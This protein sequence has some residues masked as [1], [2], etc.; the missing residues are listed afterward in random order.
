MIL[1]TDRLIMRP[2][3]DA[4]REPFAAMNADPA[5][6]EYFPAPLTREE[7]DAFVD[8]IVANM[9]RDGYGLWALEV[10]NRFIGYTGLA[11]WTSPV[12]GDEFVE[13]GWRLA[14]H[15]W[16]HGYATEAA[17]AAL[18]EGFDRF[19]LPVIVSVTARANERSQRVMRRLGMVRDPADDFDHPRVPRDSPLVPHVRYHLTA[20]AW[21]AQRGGPAAA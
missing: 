13:V 16:G 18:A 5:V 21:R 2:W 3:R 10:D 9:E 11:P 14:R 17:R 12:R 20:D 7:S 15:A 8:R 19:G 1:R 4:D 6:M